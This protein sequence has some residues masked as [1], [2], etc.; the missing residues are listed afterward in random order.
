MWD[1]PLPEYIKIDIYSYIILYIYI[2]M[3]IF[4]IYKSVCTNI[5]YSHVHIFPQKMLQALENFG[6][7]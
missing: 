1:V 2:Q 4:Y 6:P 3:Y 7:I 5:A